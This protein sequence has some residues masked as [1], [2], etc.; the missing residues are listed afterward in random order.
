MYK[1]KKLQRIRKYPAYG[2]PAIILAISNKSKI[3]RDPGNPHKPRG[4]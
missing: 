4:L 2:I 1:H 3:D